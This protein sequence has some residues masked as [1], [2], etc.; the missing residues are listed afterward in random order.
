MTILK[1]TSAKGAEYLPTGYSIKELANG[2]VRY[3][4]KGSYAEDIRTLCMWLRELQGHKEAPTTP[5]AHI[6]TYTA[7]GKCLVCGELTGKHK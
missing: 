2:D 3:E 7:N 1:K 4:N 5:C 6:A